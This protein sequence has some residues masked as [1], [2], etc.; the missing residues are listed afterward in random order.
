M[1]RYASLGTNDLARANVF[2]DAVLSHLGLQPEVLPSVV[3][4]GLPGADEE[5]IVLAITKPYDNE[6]ATA[7]N[8]T[9][10]ALRAESKA[11]VDALHATAIAQGGKS[12]GEPGFRPQYGPRMY[13]GYFRDLDGNKLS[14]VHLEP[15]VI[16]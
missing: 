10:I 1:I 2:Y 4:Y 11:Q 3:F 15:V 9:M 6:P 5:E 7:G 16:E 12:E 13:V 8:G 14:I